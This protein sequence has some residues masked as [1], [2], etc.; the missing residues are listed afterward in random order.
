[1]FI[2]VTV[3]HRGIEGS[4]LNPERRVKTLLNVDVIR[5][6]EPHAEGSFL[7]IADTGSSADYLVVTEPFEYFVEEL[8]APSEAQ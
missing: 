2:L 5:T 4:V 6:I 8:L 3:F 1:M 7:K